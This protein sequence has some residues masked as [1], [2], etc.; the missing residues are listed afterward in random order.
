MRFQSEEKCMAQKGKS[1]DRLHVSSPCDADWETMPGDERVRFCNQCRLNVYNISA[2][3]R[4]Q[5][6][7]LIA[8]TEGRLCAKLYRRADGTIITRDCPVGIRAIKRRLSHVANAAL[9]A[10]LGIFANQTI[11]WAEDGHENCK[12]YTARIVRLQ[13]TQTTALIL[14]TVSDVNGA[15]ISSA[16]VT[17]INEETRREYSSET[18]G[19]GKYRFHS[20]PAGSYSIVIESRGFAV[21]RKKAIKINEDEALQLDVTMQVGSMGGAAFLPKGLEGEKGNG[22]Q[23]SSYV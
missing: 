5:A 1:L 11:V 17:I 14:G 16:K 21:F 3:T 10:I 22:S 6:E 12:H 2:L 15:R 13:T 8:E 9:G 7:K 18:D 20:L 4:K 23:L 19:G